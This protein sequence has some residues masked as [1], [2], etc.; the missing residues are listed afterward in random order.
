MEKE[1][2]KGVFKMLAFLGVL[3]PA[4][5]LLVYSQQNF[6]IQHLHFYT[7]NTTRK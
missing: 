6:K 7:L 3:I 2:W 1:N 4:V 5:G